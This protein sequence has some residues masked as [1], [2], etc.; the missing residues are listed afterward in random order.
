MTE[1][2][3]SSKVN[4]DPQHWDQEAERVTRAILA[5]GSSGRWLGQPHAVWAA[6]AI[7]VAVAGVVAGV[8]A[9]LPRP[10]PPLDTRSAWA[11]VLAPTE[12]AGRLIAVRDRPPSIG[13]LM[14]ASDFT[15]SG[16]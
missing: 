6:A 8:T 15:R 3:D 13:A 9:A 14:L 4:D 1:I 10:V 12:P 2:F 5:S 11:A 16:R 7:V